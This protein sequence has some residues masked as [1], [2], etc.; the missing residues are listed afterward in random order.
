MT[1][2][3]LVLVAALAAGGASACRSAAPRQ[4]PEAAA[5]RCAGDRDGVLTVRNFTG[6]VIEVYAS[7]PDGPPELLA[8]VSPGVTGMD[9]PGPADQAVRYFAVDPAAGAQIGGVSWLRPTTRSARGGVV[10]ELTCRP[11]PAA[12]GGG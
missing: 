12:R 1:R 3:L 8:K 11:P 6:H 5:A 10:L 4:T 2:R 9:V 7:R